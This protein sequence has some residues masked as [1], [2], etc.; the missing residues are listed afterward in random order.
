MTLLSK[1]YLDRDGED[2]IVC[3]YAPGSTTSPEHRG[4]VS[5]INA[6]VLKGYK[7]LKVMAYI[8]PN[9]RYF[10]MLW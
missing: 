10:V 9:L 8:V 7:V 6:R 1:W 4:I 2:V 3:G 5:E